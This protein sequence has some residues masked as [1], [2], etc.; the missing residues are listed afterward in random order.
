MRIRIVPIILALVLALPL[1]VAGRAGA[2]DMAL[3]GL[4]SSAEEG[5]M[6]GVVVSAK[7]DGGTVTVSVVSDEKG[8]YAF[9]AAR[10]APGHYALSIRAAGY[11]LA[12]AGIADVAPGKGTRAD[13]ALRKTRNL[14]AQLT[15]A[16]WMASMP[17][18]DSRKKFL[19]DCNECHSLNR[20][21]SST[22]TA[23]EFLKVFDRMMHYCPCSMPTQP[24]QRK[25]AR[26]LPPESVLRPTAEW[27][28][29]V[30][31]STGPTWSYPLHTLPRPT[32]RATHVVIT[33][34]AL[35][36]SS[37][38]PHDVLVDRHGIVWFSEFGQQFIGRMDPRTGKVAEYPVPQLREGWPMGALDLEF[39]KDQN[40][41]LGMQFQAGFA[42]FDTHTKKLAEWTIPGATDASQVG[43][44]TPTAARVDGKVWMKNVV[45]NQLFR[46]DLATQKFEDLGGMKDPVTGRLINAYGIPADSQNNLYLL[47]FSTG[48][49]GRV[50]AKTTA[51]TIYRTPTVNARPRRGRVDAQDRLW[52]AE[53]AGNAIGMLDPKTAQIKEWVMPTPWSSPYDVAVDKNGDAWTA[54][55]WSDRVDRLDPKTGTITE[56]PLPKETN[57]RH[58]FIDNRTSPVSF[59]VGSNHGAAIIK[60]EPMD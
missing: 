43:M 13:L 14:A 36:K 52:F 16:E 19:L 12:G 3:S 56:Y 39:D 28:A 10:L 57:I 4:V 58:V 54:S 17:G 6:E 53:Y 7:K 35:P 23:D 44:V 50:D 31:L 42:K 1:A 8:H 11:D 33:E 45:P 26:E 40:L 55:M 22:H 49:I 5:A 27:L 48:L 20:I 34:Y 18:P 29:S 25:V 9:P 15:D 60:L 37:T 2:A 41:W 24:Q 32:G 21:V 38:E 51:L 47:D 59:W 30:N 46:F